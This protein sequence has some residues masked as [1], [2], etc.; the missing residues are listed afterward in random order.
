ML[1]LG[2]DHG[3]EAVVGRRTPTGPAATPPSP[4]S[5]YYP[6]FGRWKRFLLIRML[7][8]LGRSLDQRGV[9]NSTIRNCN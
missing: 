5:C 3:G 8:V 6:L 7:R 1:F 2:D 9:G 4:I